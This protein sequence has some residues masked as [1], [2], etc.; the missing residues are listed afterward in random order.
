LN[1]QTIKNKFPIPV[2]ED[3]LDELHGAQLFSKFDLRSGY[4]QIRMHEADIHK[5][6]FSTHLGHYEYLVMPF[7]L[8]NAPATFQQLMNTIFA[9]YL[10]KFV[11]VF[12]DDVLVYSKNVEEH[13]KHLEI[14][15][16]IFQDNKLKAKLSKCRFEQTQVEYLGHI[17]SGTG[18]AT[19]PSKI[20]D[21]IDWKTPQTIKQLRGFLGLAGYYRRF[22]P[23]YALICQPLHKAL[24]KNS[25]AW[26]EEQQLAFDKLKQVMSQPP[27][28][29][30]P[31]FSMPFTL[32]TDACDTGLGAVLMQQARPLAYFSRALGP[33]NAALSV[34]EKEA[35]A[36]METLKK[37]RH[38]FLGNKLIIRT[39]Q[40]SLKYITSQRLLEGIQ[41]KLMLKL[42]E[43]DY[44]IQ[45]KKG[46]ENTAADAL[47]RKNQPPEIVGEQEKCQALA[48]AVPSWTHDI[49]ASYCSDEVASKLLQEVTIAP[50][51]HANYSVQS[52]IL[53]Y[54]GRLY[55]GITTDLKK[56]VFDSFHSSIFGGHS[57]ARVTYHKLKHSFYWPKMKQYVAEQI[58]VCPVCQI[59]KTEKVQYPG[60]LEPLNIP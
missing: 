51:S 52:G 41:H 57:G 31:N 40:C 20:Q 29:A 1:E 60:L 23:H 39:D 54:K 38:Y 33:K 15:M 11:L 22:I 28:L 3:L 21:I 14:V 17:I 7:G 43:F 58:A 37:W 8:C 59:S 56:R 12:F 30:L 10:R 50:T 18:V 19:D 35:L 45:Y 4:H 25:F 55:I 26:E 47:S 49:T 9:P 6:A 24:K 53:R 2:I 48:M 36:I 32:E 13:N 46:S 5:T 42:L 27:L 16:Q 34:Y 44:S